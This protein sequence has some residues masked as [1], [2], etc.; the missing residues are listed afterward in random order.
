M[1]K[2]QTHDRASF[3]LPLSV[4]E[5]I[6][7]QPNSRGDV[8]AQ[9]VE[10]AQSAAPF[11][12]VARLTLELRQR[13]DAIDDAVAEAQDLLEQIEVA[14]SLAQEDKTRTD[15]WPAGSLKQSRAAGGS[16]AVQ[17]LAAAGWPLRRVT[18]ALGSTYADHPS[19]ALS[20]AQL[21]RI[22][23]GKYPAKPELVRAIQDVTGVDLSVCVMV[24]D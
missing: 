4:I 3:Y 11:P 18:A 14:A 23:A 16:P 8:I 5:W 17:L 24:G 20:I 22:C 10:R 21:S 7:S 1:P 15:E 6:D 12:D 9:L 19:I 2:K 13:L